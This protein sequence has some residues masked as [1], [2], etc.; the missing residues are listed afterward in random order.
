MEEKKRRNQYEFDKRKYDHI[1]LQTPKG[2]KAEIQ[3]HAEAQGKSL[4]GFV[5]EAIEEKME[6]DKQSER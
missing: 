2:R 3:A 1:H 4:N 5:N 6:R